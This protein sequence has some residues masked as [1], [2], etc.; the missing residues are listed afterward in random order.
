MRREGKLPKK[1]TM[2]AQEYINYLADLSQNETKIQMRLAEFQKSISELLNLKS[3]AERK[4]S[5]ETIPLKMHD[6]L[7]A[8]HMI[9]GDVIEIRNIISAVQRE[10]E[11]HVPAFIWNIEDYQGLKDKS[12]SLKLMLRRIELD[13]PDQQEAYQFIDDQKI[14]PFS[15]QAV[16]YSMISILGHRQ[17]ILMKIASWYL[18]R[19][20]LMQAY[21][22][23]S[24]VQ[25]P[26]EDVLEMK[27]QLG[28]ILQQKADS[29]DQ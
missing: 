17:E 23:L 21:M 28:Q 3:D 14:S 15:V 8:N 18:D 22:F 9:S 1:N 7:Y 5:I 29:H 4:K 11:G 25:N 16:I 24:V 10:Y 27:E 19:G 12:M 20:C 2:T 6:E 13:L 26:T